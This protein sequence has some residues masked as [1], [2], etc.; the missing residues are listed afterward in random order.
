M[1]RLLDGL[2]RLIGA[3]TLA[4]LVLALGLIIGAGHWMRVNDA[5]KQADYIIPLAGKTSR[6]IK[7]AELYHQGFAPVILMSNARELPPSRLDELRLEIG[8]PNYETHEY[9]ARL[10][11]LLG[12]GDAMGG[13]FGNG[14]ISTVEEAEALKAHLAGSTPRLLLVTSPTHTRRAKMVFESTLP[15][16][17]IT[18]VAT[19]EDGFDNT[20]WRDQRMAQFLVMEFAKTAHYLLGGVFRSTDGSPTAADSGK[21]N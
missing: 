19:D 17:E 8:F 21:R 12:V 4:G 9:H 10:A 14:H 15:E 7:A 11:A 13:S 5:P 1:R 2:L 16:C 6:L 3:V 18:V 20:W